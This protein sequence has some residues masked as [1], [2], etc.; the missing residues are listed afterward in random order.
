MEVPV[1]ENGASFSVYKVGVVQS[2]RQL[3]FQLNDRMSLSEN[4]FR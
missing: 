1:S 3:R 2:T 4:V